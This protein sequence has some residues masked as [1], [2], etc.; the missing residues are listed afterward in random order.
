MTDERK[1]RV[2]MIG[3]GRLSTR[4]HYP[5]LHSMPDVDLVAVA[6]L[7]PERAQAAAQRFGIPQTY[8]DFRKMLA[9]ADPEVVY[10]VMP[11][12]YL[13]EPAGVV[14]DQGR[15]LF[16]EKPLGLTTWQARALAH[17]AE[18]R[19]CLT[20]VGFQ[21]RFA[22]ALTELRRRLDQRGPVHHIT[23]SFLKCLPFERPAAEYGG[24]IDMFTVD[25]IH[26]AD[27]LRFLG[28]EVRGV[29]AAV[30]NHCHPGPF[31][32]SVTALVSFSSGAVGVWRSDYGTGRRIF[33]AELHG[34]GA[35]AHFDPD[36]DCLFVADNGTAEVRPSRSFGPA[37]A[38]DNRPEL[39]LGFWHEARHFI[40]CVKG[41]TLPDNHF[42]DAV[43]SMELVERVLRAAE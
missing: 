39:W 17:R 2:A 10:L 31:P 20:A 34:K 38:P 9:E 4:F 30:R 43:R 13:F 16:V 29:T 33:Q 8:T 1:V 22:P 27:L 19:T 28:G 40:D 35:T 5:S 36:G 12:Q 11:P 6:D 24:V 25:G 15:N 26:A 14:L 41:R 32:D 37:D 7:V 21:R 42:G 18:A 23:V 3:A